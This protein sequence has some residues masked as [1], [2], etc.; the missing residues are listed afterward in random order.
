MSV[1]HCHV[2]VW[3]ADRKCVLWSYWEN[4]SITGIKHKYYFQN[5]V[6]FYIIWVFAHI[7]NVFHRWKVF[8]WL[9]FYVVPT[10]RK[11]TSC[12]PLA[13]LPVS[14]ACPTGFHS[15]YIYCVFYQFAFELFLCIRMMLQSEMPL[16]FLCGNL[17]ISC[18]L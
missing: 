2:F 8:L 12:D 16:S 3:F 7:C 6:Q 1:Y 5:M 18:S 10:W 4:C 15:N 17:G 9:T 13:S 11:P 14:A